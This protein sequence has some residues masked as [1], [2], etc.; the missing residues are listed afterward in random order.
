VNVYGAERR[1][2]Y[3]VR[4][5]GGSWILQTRY[6]FTASSPDIRLALRILLMLAIQAKRRQAMTVEFYPIRPGRCINSLWNRYK[7]ITSTFAFT[8]M[9][10]VNG[11]PF[12]RIALIEDHGHA[13]SNTG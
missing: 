8:F 5:S 10:S 9:M 7:R 11:G 4:R 13:D 6:E 3:R 2:N 12:S 1:S